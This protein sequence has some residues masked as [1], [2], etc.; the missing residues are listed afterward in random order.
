M[1]AFRSEIYETSSLIQIGA[2]EIASELLRQQG[3]CGR[4]MVSANPR[5]PEDGALALGVRTRADDFF[6][7]LR[8]RLKNEPAVNFGYSTSY[9][10]FLKE[11]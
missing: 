5:S 3:N 11:D 4:S 9:I 7:S 8:P 10:R 6:G 1:M 2:L